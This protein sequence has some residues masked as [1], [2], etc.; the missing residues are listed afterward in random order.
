M[1]FIATVNADGQIQLGEAAHRA[2]FGP[3]RLVEV[4]V[5]KAGSLIVAIDP[6]PPTVDVPFKPLPG[7]PAR[8]ALIG[9][10]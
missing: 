8:R 1:T 4:I 5:T 10:G 2:G 6:S 7:R 3:G 9:G